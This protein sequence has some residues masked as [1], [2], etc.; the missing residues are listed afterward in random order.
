MAALRT[1]MN[2][3]PEAML[4]E[5]ASATAPS[6]G[7]AV[8]MRA[9]GLASIALVLCVALGEPAGAGFGRADATPILAPT[10]LSRSLAG[11]LA[12]TSLP[13]ARAATHL[14]VDPDAGI[15]RS[16][17]LDHVPEDTVKFSLPVQH[18]GARKPTVPNDESL[19][20]NKASAK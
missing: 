8:A 6:S 3:L 17:S 12:L 1:I 7:P 9:G 10:A 11:S 5:A 4:A 2:G 19:S 18:P 14:R 16:L 20:H 15:I 13:L